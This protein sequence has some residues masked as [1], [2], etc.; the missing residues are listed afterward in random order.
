MSLHCVAL[1]KSEECCTNN[2]LL[3]LTNSIDLEP[4]F[5]SNLVPLL[6]PKVDLAISKLDT[7]ILQCHQ[8]IQSAKGTRSL[9][10]CNF[11]CEFIFLLYRS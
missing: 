6:I 9:P 11:T 3:P 10:C 2:Y 7:N 4:T 1:T 5:R 8:H